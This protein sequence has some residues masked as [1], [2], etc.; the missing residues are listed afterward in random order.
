MSQ[1]PSPKLRALI[2]TRFSDPK[3]IGNQSTQVQLSSCRDYCTRE[4][5]SVI[6]VD[7]VEALNAKITNTKRI[8]HLLDFC[9]QYKGQA[10]VLVVFKL[11]RFARDEVLHY[12]LRTELEKLGMKLRS[13]TEPID[14]SPEGRLMETV[15]AGIAAYDNRIKSMRTRLSMER[16]VKEHGIYPWKAPT[17][18]I[19]QK[20]NHKRAGVAVLD[21]TYGL[22]DELREA[23]VKFSTGSYSYADLRKYLNQ[24]KLLNHKKRAVT[25]KT[26]QSIIRLLTNPFYA[27][28]LVVSSWSKEQYK[29]AHEPLVDMALFNKV[30]ERI[31]GKATKAR[32]R[33]HLA[34]NPDFPLRDKLHCGYCSGKMTACWTTSKS[35]KK[36]AYYY[37]P[38]S[39]CPNPHRRSIRRDDFEN[40]VSGL[41][42]FDTTAP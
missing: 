22:A 14:E 32:N 23:Y 4:G 17:G 16:L 42:A 15:L 2:S 28:L 29:G 38:K 30:K 21:N 5:M 39:K 9:E 11:D 25:F 31:E 6:G 12:Y 24:K 36:F 1:S 41:S 3:Q 7:T 10:D 27:G 40:Q 8:A 26:D 19:N 34:I 35:G 20:N 37:C 13:A 33:E 18:Y